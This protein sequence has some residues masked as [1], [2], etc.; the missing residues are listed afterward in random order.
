M[1]VNYN[2]LFF[3]IMD[4]YFTIIKTKHFYDVISF[5]LTVIHTKKKHVNLGYHI[6]NKKIH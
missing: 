6:S 1:A 4:F 3:Q 5:N 2:I